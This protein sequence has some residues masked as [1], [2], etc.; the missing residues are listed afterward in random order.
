M[1]RRTSCW[2]LAAGLCCL[3]GTPG[4]AQ[5]REVPWSELP[6]KVA[7]RLIPAESLGVVD[8][9]K[10]LAQRGPSRRVLQW[11]EN[12]FYS[13]EEYDLG[14]ERGASFCVVMV[15]PHRQALSAGDAQVLLTASNLWEEQALAAEESQYRSLDDPRLKDRRPAER[16]EPSN[17]VL[18]D[19]GEDHGL[20]RGIVG[21]ESNGE[22]DRAQEP[23]GEPRK[24]TFEEG[25]VAAAGDGK[26][27]IGPTD[28]RRRVTGSAAFPFNGL[29]YLAFD[30]AKGGM[31]ASGFLVSPHMVLTNGHVV[32]DAQGGRFSR[33]MEIV[34]GQTQGRAGE[35]PATPFGTRRAVRFATNAGWVETQR[36]EFDYSAAFF[37]TPFNGITTFMPL[38]FDVGPG[39]GGIVNVAGYP[40]EVGREETFGLWLD[41][42][43][44]ES[45]QGRVL[46]HKVDTSGGNSGSPVWETFSATGLRRAIAVHSSG[47]PL[48]IANSAA[49]LVSQ[50]FELIS[51]WLAWTPAASRRFQLTINQI[52][53]D[54]CPSVSAIVSVVDS[55][56]KPVADLAPGN[57]RLIENGV[58]QRIH[59]SQGEVGNAPVSLTLVL[60]ASG[61]LSTTDVANIRAASRRFIDLLGPRDKVAVYHFANGV[62]RAVDYTT[63]KDRAK[64]AVDALDN[65]GG[66]VGDGSAT[67]LFDAVIEAALH[68][69]NVS[70]RRALIAMTDGNN[71]TGSGGLF[72]AI[73]T[74]RSAAVPV[75][76]VGFGSA[77]VGVLDLMARETGGRFFFGS[78]STDLQA[79]LQAIGRALDN[80][81]I[82]SWVTS[83]ISGGTQNIEIQ[84][85]EGNDRDVKSATYSQSG[86]SCRTP[87][88]CNV[89]VIS[90]NGNEVWTKGTPQAIRWKST[91]PSCGAVGIGISNGPDIWPLIDVTPN[92]GVQ[93]FN[94]DFLPL[95][96]NYKAVV[97]DRSSVAPGA[98]DISDGTFAVQANTA[99]FTCK[100]GPEAQCLVKNRF[101][102]RVLWR[103]P[104]GSGFAKAVRLTDTSAYFWFFDSATPELVVKLVDGRPL[105][106][107]FWIYSGALTSLEYSVFV[108]DSTT[109]NTRVYN[110]QEGDF[111]SFG[112]ITAFGPP[113]EVENASARP[114]APA[115]PSSAPEGQASSALSSPDAAP[116]ARTKETVLWNQTDRLSNVIIS[117]ENR[118]DS[119]ADSLDT[120]GADDFVV[121]AKK[122]WTLRGVDVLGGYFG[123][124]PKGPASSVNVVVYSDANGLP[125]IPQCTYNRVRPQRGLDTGS[126]EI[127]LAQPCILIE[128]RYWVA[129]QSNQ[130]FN[131]AG[132]W[133]WLQRSQQR[134]RAAVWRN[135][136]NGYNSGCPSWNR[137]EAGCRLSGEPDLVFRLRGDSGAAGSR[138]CSASSTALC[139]NG[140]RFKVE[141]TYVDSRGKT[142]SAKAVSISGQSGYFW[143][144]NATGP[145]VAVKILDGRLVN[146]AFWLFYGGASDAE[147]TL[148][149][150][151]S[152]T[153]RVKTY[154]NRRGRLV[155]TGDLNAFPGP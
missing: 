134:E 59:V 150:T 72:D 60:D 90:P 16:W 11:I 80:Q 148:R 98:Q 119:G 69:R 105:N 43:R 139:L 107:H 9:P 82:L 121:P 40:G 23:E 92:D 109:G 132:Q 102:V 36:I 71:N 27:V 143:F 149:I 136:G 52:D 85:A 122:L 74:A 142:V 87:T 123:N 10:D 99:G 101:H 128:G 67:A 5:T 4:N 1:R 111:T 146:N 14:K 31:R 56:G 58:E 95:G 96:G 47:D 155:S 55:A 97:V 94:I 48:K 129:V 78:S 77:D 22:K 42:D 53:P 65:Q 63:D 33:N 39:A 108:T 133:G 81:Y 84:V 140:K 130:D 114:D 120:E 110:S 118:L 137:M 116:W 135:P 34:P 57:F 104:Q 93:T 70:G 13:W 8:C 51:E 62:A 49:R 125:G 112:D 64:A 83:F 2:L 115:T 15:R 24:K 7:D 20:D 152:L 138:S 46:R 86:T 28:D 154:V 88:T 66:I 131:I 89:Q 100:V 17:R 91:G 144:F 21:W 127:N 61:S 76:T 151:D 50:N 73:A 106:A 12:V 79:I 41:D 32:W 75:F 29:T 153:G 141:A 38:V 113:V 126:F 3:L 44:V 18:K 35:V 45:V 68:S 37:E 103:G 26:T 30:T 19:L 117:S 6:A 145:D 54:D 25:G 147:Y 124:G